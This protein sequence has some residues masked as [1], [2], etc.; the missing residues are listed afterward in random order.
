MSHNNGTHMSQNKNHGNRARLS[1][2][3]LLVQLIMD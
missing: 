3:P 1:S 2:T